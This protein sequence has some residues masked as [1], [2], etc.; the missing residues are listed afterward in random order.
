MILCSSSYTKYPLL[1][2]S[3]TISIALRLHGH[4]IEGVNIT[5]VILYRDLKDSQLLTPDDDLGTMYACQSAAPLSEASQVMKP[6]PAPKHISV[7]RVDGWI[8]V[9]LESLN[10]LRG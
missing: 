8:P 3:R 4:Q 2:S 10:M 1:I 5:F 7:L 6:P 9:I